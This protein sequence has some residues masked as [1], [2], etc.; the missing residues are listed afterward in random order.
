MIAGT[1]DRRHTMTCRP[2]HPPRHP[3]FEPGN[4]AARRHG[5]WAADASDEAALVVR[6]QRPAT[7]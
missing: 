3:P 6:A 1:D 2:G 4:R 7:P 5:V